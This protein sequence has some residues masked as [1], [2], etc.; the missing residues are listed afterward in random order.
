MPRRDIYGNP[1]TYWFLKNTWEQLINFD[2]DSYN[3][4]EAQQEIIYLQ[5]LLY[6]AWLSWTY[7]LGYPHEDSIELFE[8]Y[9]EAVYNENNPFILL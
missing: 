5:H 9:L 6:K 7:W 4:R 2:E 1:L 8:D 3:E